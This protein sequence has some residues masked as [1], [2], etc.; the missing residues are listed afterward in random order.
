MTEGAVGV[1]AYRLRRAKISG[2]AE[3]QRQRGHRQ[4]KM[5]PVIAP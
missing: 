2:T 1:A 5:A 3:L 4:A